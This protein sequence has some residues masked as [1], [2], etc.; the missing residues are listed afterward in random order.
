MKIHEHLKAVEEAPI[1]S[2]E[3]IGALSL[4]LQICTYWS[5][6]KPILKL[7]KLFT[8]AE[9]DAK[10]DQCIAWGDNICP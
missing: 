6:I 1:P 3:Q 5:L 9:A 10:I 7:I 2:A 4:V 8:G